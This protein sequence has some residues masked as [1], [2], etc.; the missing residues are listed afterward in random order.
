M[1]EAELALEEPMEEAHP[2]FGATALRRLL[3]KR[4]AMV[5]LVVILVIY[6]AGILAPLVAPYGYN[7]Q[8]LDNAFAG[9]SLAHPLGTDRLGRDML[10]R[11]IWAS[12]TTVIISAAAIFTG[13]LVLGVGLGLLAGY[14]GGR[15][16]NFIM[17]V[18]DAFFALPDILLLLLITATVRPRVE[19][20]FDK[21]ESWPVAGGLVKGGA[22]DYFL[23]F[24]ALA[25]FGWVGIARLIRSQ[26]L[27]LRES[28]YVLAARAMGASLGRI[29]ARHLLPNVTNIIVVS[30]TISLG[31]MA[32]TEIMLS[33]LGIGITY[34]HPSFGAM[35]AEGSD[36]S[37]LRAHP[38]ILLVPATVVALLLFAFNLLG[39]ALNDVLSP[40]RR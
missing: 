9:P 5:C 33:W 4:L 39:D 11:V 37:S 10:S 38:H 17:R 25:L 30:V 19:A 26:V 27:S 32:G 35:I 2:R 18:A 29:L 24:G 14:A 20:L 21:F 36:L 31:A 15:V 12:Q 3:R 13:G 7:K 1:A 34:P 22:P 8:E 40:R 6:L 23:V 28:D 16:D